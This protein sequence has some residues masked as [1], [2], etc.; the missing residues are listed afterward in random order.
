MRREPPGGILQE[1]DVRDVSAR[2]DP[3][4]ETLGFLFES[5]L[6]VLGQERNVIQP[7][8]DKKDVKHSETFFLCHP[9]D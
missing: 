8:A 4:L 9:S 5:S 3:R 1:A 7:I 2:Y 6:R